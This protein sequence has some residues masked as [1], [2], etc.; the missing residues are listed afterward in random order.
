MEIQKVQSA[1][2]LHFVVKDDGTAGISSLYFSSSPP[3]TPPHPPLWVTVQDAMSDKC[4]RQPRLWCSCQ[5][6]ESRTSLKKPFLFCLDCISFHSG[7]NNTVVA[8]DLGD[9]STYSHYCS[10]GEVIH[11]AHANTAGYWFSGWLSVKVMFEAF[12]SPGTLMKSI[13]QESALSVGNSFTA[14]LN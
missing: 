5:D 4:V 6:S 8:F 1:Y 7:G 14:E 2:K 10:E 13:W 12:L 11:L 9:K 3:H